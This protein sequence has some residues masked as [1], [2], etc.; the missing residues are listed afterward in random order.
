MGGRVRPGQTTGVGR[1]R[2]G[3]PCARKRED[4]HRSSLHLRMEVAD[5]VADDGLGA[6]SR[7]ADAEAVRPASGRDRRGDG[8]RTVGSHRTVS[9]VQPLVR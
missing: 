4:E 6:V 5:A 3:R 1:G 7:R 8:S 2:D 9:I